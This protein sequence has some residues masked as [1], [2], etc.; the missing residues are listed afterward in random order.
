MPSRRVGFGFMNCGLSAAVW[1]MAQLALERRGDVAG[2]RRLAEEALAI[3]EAIGARSY[4]T[5]IRADLAR[6]DDLEGKLE[7][8]TRRLEAIRGDAAAVTDRD[9]VA[10]IEERLGLIAV[11]RGELDRAAERFARA[12]AAQAPD[13][14]RQ[15]ARVEA[16]R[17]GAAGEDDPALFARFALA[18]RDPAAVARARALA[19]AAKDPALVVK[20]TRAARKR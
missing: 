18:R 5:R 20:L 10:E 8:A 15:R 17:R 12:A 6:Y 7:E 11:E 9:L 4:A 16:V 1:Q 14:A 3:A 13:E 2:A 19:E